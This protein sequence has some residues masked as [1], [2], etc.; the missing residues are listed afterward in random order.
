VIVGEKNL[1]NS[2]DTTLARGA[3]TA[4]I[5]EAGRGPLAGPVIASA[6]ILTCETPPYPFADS[7]TINE[8]RREL[9][10]DWLISTSADIGI[11]EASHQEIDEINIHNAS[12]L[13]MKRAVLSLKS[14]PSK[15]LIDGKF[16]IE[17]NI[18]QEA[19]IKGDSKVEAISAASIV[20]KVT[21]DRLMKKYHLLFPQYG[22]AQHKGYPT[23]A[24]KEAIA[25]YGPS[26]IHRLTFKG[27][28]PV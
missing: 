5:D 14:L 16:T 19:I 9:L 7:K 3:T 1:V 12:L 6:V 25:V 20:A 4:G 18:N 13:A 22:L 24:H 8:K 17:M 21:R 15:L 23:K 26:P 27:V 28:K 11:G 2:S 10:Y